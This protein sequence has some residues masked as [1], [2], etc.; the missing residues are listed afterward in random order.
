MKALIGIPHIFK[1]REGSIYSSESAC[2]KNAKEKAL[3]RATLENIYRHRKK[4]WIHAS[5]GMQKSVITRKL[6]GAIGA[7]LTIH[8]YTDKRYSLANKVKSDENIKI[9]DLPVDDPKKIPLIAS[10]NIIEN[11]GK[12]DMIGYM[13]DDILIEDPEFFSK[14][15]FLARS[16]HNNYVFLPHRC[17]E[18]PCKGD[19]ILSG[20]PDGGRPDLFWDTGEK[21]SV[22]WPLGTRD[23][24]RATN[25]HSG[26]YF[27]NKSQGVRLKEYWENKNWKAEFTLSGPLEQAASGLLLPV[28]K[29]MKPIPEHYRFLMV[30]HQ[31]SL[32]ERHPF[33]EE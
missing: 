29:I 7:D 31:D 6:V 4:H 14:I 5:L 18:I 23:F 15:D 30:K 32:W 8:I 28:F 10:R 17:E 25:P 33:E 3:K 2:K 20:D 11:A 22:P 27:L 16:T 19:V 26:C 1:P 9:I 12:Y 21:V 13:E 24:Y